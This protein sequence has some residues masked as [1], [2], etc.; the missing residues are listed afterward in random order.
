MASVKLCQA[1][2]DPRTCQ[3]SGESLWEAIE[4]VDGWLVNDT[5]DNRLLYGRYVL[6][7]IKSQT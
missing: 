4:T 5:E 6:N 2:A 7:T 3:H 1:M